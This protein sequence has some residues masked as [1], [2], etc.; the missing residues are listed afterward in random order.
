MI[1]LTLKAH[2]PFR[3]SLDGITPG[4][5]AAMAPAELERRPLAGGNRRGVIGDW[6]RVE[7]A[8]EPADRLVI[9]ADDDL[10]DDVGAGMAGGELIV[11]GDVGAGAGTAMSGGLLRIAGAAGYGAATAMR[12]GELRIAGDVG[13][14]LGGALPGER[15]GMSEGIVI[16]GGKAGGFVGDRMRRGLIV[17]A[18]SAGPFCAA[19][20]LAGTIVVGGAIGADPGVAMRRGTLVALS[21]VIQPTA[22]FA[23]CG[24]TELTVLRLI[25]RFLARS[26]LAP[27][28]GRIGRLRRRVGD[29]AQNGKGEILAP[30]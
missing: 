3:L 21:G 19:R 22:G 15:T 16:V 26:G 17:V 24:I 23:D 9:V 12:G 11:E 29:L 5:V 4:R 27:L 1:R 10:L 18:E 13:D 6:F 30:P 2:P 28:A 14:Q 25:G 8:G 7:T 20:M